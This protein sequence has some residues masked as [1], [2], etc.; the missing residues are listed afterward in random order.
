MLTECTIQNNGGYHRGA[1]VVVSSILTLTRCMIQSNGGGAVF[2][3]ALFAV[4]SILT[5]SENIFQNNTAELSGAIYIYKNNTLILT[6]N[7]FQNN[8]AKSSEGG[9]GA[10]CVLENN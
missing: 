8:V 6:H 7:T 10:L 5:L 4:D 2:G 9:G 3:G 1:L